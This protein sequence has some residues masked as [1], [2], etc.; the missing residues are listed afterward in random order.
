MSSFLDANVNDVA[1][2]GFHIVEKNLLLVLIVN[3]DHGMFRCPSPQRLIS[4]LKEKR[5]EHGTRFTSIS[6]TRGGSRAKGSW[7]FIYRP[8]TPKYNAKGK[9]C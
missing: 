4:R 5:D 9:S 2:P 1:I 3:L 6:R 8:T 7:R